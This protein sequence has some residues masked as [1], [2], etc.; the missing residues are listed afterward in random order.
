[1]LYDSEVK[2]VLQFQ[3]SSLCYVNMY[4]TGYESSRRTSILLFL[5]YIQ[6]QLD[7]ILYK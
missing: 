2:H 1:M 6:V 7:K 3:T 4:C 5:L